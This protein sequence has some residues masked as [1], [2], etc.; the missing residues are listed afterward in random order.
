MIAIVAAME[1]AS[2][3]KL[4]QLIA[5]KISAQANFNLVIVLMSNVI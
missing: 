4:G 3:L 5:L 2:N 1:Y